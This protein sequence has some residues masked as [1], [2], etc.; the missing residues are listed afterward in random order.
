MT[1][2]APTL[3]II[4]GWTYTT[5]YWTNTIELLESSGI[6]VKMLH[7]PGL[8]TE[9]SKTYTISDYVKW[10]NENLPENAIAL[11]HSNGGRI[12]M[13]LATQK[14]TK[15]KHLILLNSAGIFH[16]TFRIRVLRVASKAFFFLG[17]IPLVRKVLYKII[18]VTDYNSAPPNMKKTLDNMIQSDK[19][20]NIAQVKTPTSILWGD[21][22]KTTP[23]WQGQ[24]IHSEIANSTFKHF[25][26]WDHS[27]YIKHPKQLAQEIERI[28]K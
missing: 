17:K 21:Q 7:V 1:N 13:N 23:L 8:T 28:L 18:G 15:L 19:N 16:T 10:A 25:K 5:K 4:H 11:G 12:L 2:P 27:P 9:S 6:K 26:I 20:L 22:D 3:Y 24:K 14:P